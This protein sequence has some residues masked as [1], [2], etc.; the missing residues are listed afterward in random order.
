MDKIKDSVIIVREQDELVTACC[1]P[2]D[3][4][5]VREVGK[6]DLF[7]ETSQIIRTT[8]ELYQTLKNEYGDSIDMDIV[9]PRN[10]GYLFPRLLKDIFR[11]RVSFRQGLRTIFAL[12][13]PAIICNGQLIMSGKK[14]LSIQVLDRVRQ[15]IQVT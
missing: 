7:M 1:I 13:S 15:I 11:Y 9:D 14:Q 4:E 10:Q 6:V 8:G 2:F 12:R 3:G 5:F